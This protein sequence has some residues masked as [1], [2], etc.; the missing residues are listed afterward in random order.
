MKPRGKG[1]QCYLK[2]PLDKSSN[3]IFRINLLNVNQEEESKFSIGL[4][5]KEYVDQE[6]VSALNMAWEENHESDINNSWQIIRGV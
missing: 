1:V 6:Y 2:S 4:L 3:Y 5:P